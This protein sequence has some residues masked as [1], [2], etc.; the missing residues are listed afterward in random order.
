VFDGSP[1]SQFCVIYSFLGY[2]AMQCGVTVTVEKER[3][4]G[5]VSAVDVGEEFWQKYK[6][7]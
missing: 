2:Q 3:A 6:G 5:S 4:I 7:G 1:L